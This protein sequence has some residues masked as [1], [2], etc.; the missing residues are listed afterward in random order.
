M[1]INYVRIIVIFLGTLRQISVEK[2]DNAIRSFDDKLMTD[3]L[4][5]QCLACYPTPDEVNNSR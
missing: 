3:T 1:H 2:I 5:T 4:I